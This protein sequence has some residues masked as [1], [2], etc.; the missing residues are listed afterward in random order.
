MLCGAVLELHSCIAPLL[1][2]GDLLN[3]NML[4]VVMKDPVTPAPVERASSLEEPVSVPAPSEPTASE[5]EEAAQPEDFTL[6]P[7][8]RPLV[9]WVGPF[10][11]R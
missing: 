2:S 6:V 3:L 4:Y 7:K 11:G 8:R 10:L 9:P 5:P 1:E